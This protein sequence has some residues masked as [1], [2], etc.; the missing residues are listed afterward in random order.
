M[1]CDGNKKEE[2]ESKERANSGCEKNSHT[3]EAASSSRFDFSETY[4]ERTRFT[5]ETFRN[6]SFT[7][8]QRNYRIGFFPLYTHVHGVLYITER[9]GEIFFN[10][11]ANKSLR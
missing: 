2:D 4:E 11:L 3:S 9:E 6:E 10:I 5:L 8:L 7:G 1:A